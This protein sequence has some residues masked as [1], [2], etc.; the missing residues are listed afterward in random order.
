MYE[1]VNRDKDW[2]VL[3]QLKDKFKEEFIPQTLPEGWEIVVEPYQ[4]PQMAGPAQGQV[5][6]GPGQPQE[7]RTAQPPARQPVR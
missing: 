3:D 7:N 1:F 5:P 6:G 2:T 4:A